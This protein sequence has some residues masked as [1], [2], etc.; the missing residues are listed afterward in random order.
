MGPDQ[1]VLD[2]GFAGSGGGSDSLPQRKRQM[3]VVRRVTLIVAVVWL[4]LV[5]GLG[6]WMSQRILT[7][8]LDS[9]AAS[10]EYEA[11][12]T[13]RVMDRLF[14]EMVSVSNMVASQA[15][16]IELAA[17]YLT[18]APGAAELT[19]QQRAAQF[20]R[21]PLVQQVGDYMEGLAGDLNYARIYMNNMSDDTVT[22]SNWA[23]TDSIVGMIYSGRPYLMDALRHGKGSSFGIA[24][25][26]KTPSYFVSSRI[27]DEKGVP[28][29]SVTVKFDAP[30]VAHYL[31]GRHVSLVVNRQGRVITTSSA[32]FMLRNVTPLLPAGTVQPADGEEELGEPMEVSAIADA[33]EGDQWL[34]EG[35]PYLLRRQSLTNTPYELLTLASLEELAPMRMQHLVTTGLVAGLGLVLILLCGRIATQ[36]AERRLRAEQDRVLAISKAAER[37][38]TIKV[39]ERTAEL[40]ESNASLEEEVDRRH[41]LEVK[42]RQSLDSVNDALVQQRDFLA[43]VTH[44]F[45][46]PL[47]VIATA[48]DNLALAVDESA[49]DV[50]LRAARIR[51]TVNR[52]SMLIENVLAGDRLDATER[53]LAVVETFD[54]NEILRTAQGA[55]DDDAIR[56]VI[57]IPGDEAPVS[58]DRYLLEIALQNLVQNALKYSASLTSITVRLTIDD[59][60]VF[61]NVTDQGSGIPPEYREFIFLKYYRA[62][63]QRANGSGLGLY[64]SREIARQHGGELT[65]VASDDSGSTFCLSIPALVTKL[66]TLKPRLAMELL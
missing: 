1:A 49:D 19:R 21:D 12:T 64:I 10:A 23:A 22:A 30:D 51:R 35:R 52:M 61:V 26:N 65:L 33:A 36:L 2:A 57:F 18:D 47:A 39:R 58:G 60:V 13:T 55:L 7:A 56:R 3:L 59:G 42:L 48:A 50:Q 46:G 66:D 54:L 20:T 41:G 31:T 32:P 17:R 63:G 40:A 8:Q 16:V 29:G 38:L 24:R 28:L 15:Q 37:D 4:A 27:D 14:T 6:W 11:V 53:R 45:R 9:L 62:A 44:E 34:V 25:L 5:A 43:L